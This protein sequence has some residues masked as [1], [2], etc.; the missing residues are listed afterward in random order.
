VVWLRERVNFAIAAIKAGYV[1][2]TGTWR[3]LAPLL[4]LVSFFG[5]VAY[6]ADIMWPVIAV[7]A[8][9]L[10]VLVFFEGAYRLWRESMPPEPVAAASTLHELLIKG[11]SLKQWFMREFVAGGLRAGGAQPHLE[12]WTADVAAAMQTVRPNEAYLIE[13]EDAADVSTV[14]HGMPLPESHLMN[15]LIE[16]LSRLQ[17]VIAELKT[18]R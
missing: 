9:A 13:Q 15:V 1:W 6:L 14:Y 4:G 3:F 8:A 10:L 5:L 11:R 12:A 17:R 16:R 18:A 2:F 7:V